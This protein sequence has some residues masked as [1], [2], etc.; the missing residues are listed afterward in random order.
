MSLKAVPQYRRLYEKLRKHI[1]DGVYREGDL[2]PSENELCSIHK[3]TRP[4]VRKALDMLTNEG[5]IKR[6]QGKGSIV[7]KLPKGIGILSIS[8]TTGAIG[9]DNLETITVHKPVVVRWPEKF[10]FSLSDHE[11]DSGCIFFTRLRKVSGLPV[12]YDI[13]YLPNINLPR[14][15][16]RNLDNRSLFDILRTSYS[17]EIKGGEQFIRAA[18]APEKEIYDIL[19]IKKDQPVLYLQRK[20]DTNRLNYSIYSIL[21]CN[22][23][24]HSLYGI[25]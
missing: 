18:R 7:H 21:Y 12:I 4:T 5:F 8:G 9:K 25:F 2:L 22:T 15:T 13:S 23:N 11:L 6:H 24:R 1:V 14:F 17:L 20:M 19:E 10:P 16:S 3:L